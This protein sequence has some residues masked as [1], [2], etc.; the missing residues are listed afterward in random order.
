MACLLLQHHDVLLCPVPV[1]HHLAR[2]VDVD[3][4]VDVGVDGRRRNSSSSE[5]EMI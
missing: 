5:R 3:V 2:N 1:E 4:D